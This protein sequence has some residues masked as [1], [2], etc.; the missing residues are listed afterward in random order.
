MLYL[1]LLFV[2]VVLVYVLRAE[3][4]ES[5]G[6]G[7]TF[8]INDGDAD[9][10]VVVPKIETLGVPNETTN[11]VES[12]RLDLED[13]V[14]VK[15]AALKDGGTFN[16]KAQLIAATRTRIETIRKNRTKKQFRVTVPI[17]TGTIAVTVPGYITAAPIEDLEAEKI[18]VINITITVSGAQIEE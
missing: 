13:A 6:F 1:T 17:D 5:I 4:D 9:A 2:A 7:G 18:S 11:I 16:V 3:G 10:Y 8:E 12:K 15:I 14:I